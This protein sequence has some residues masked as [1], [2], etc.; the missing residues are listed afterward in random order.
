[1]GPSSQEEE[2]V[3]SLIYATFTTLSL[4][5]C[6]GS[7]APPTAAPHAA[8]SEA[9]AGDE[10]GDVPALPSA[11]PAT[12]PNEF[13]VHKSDPKTTREGPAASSK[14][15]GNA[16]HAALKFIVVDKDSG[17]IEGIIIA[18]T[19]PDG[20]KH[21]TEATNGEG[22]S[23][24]LVPVGHKYEL[25]YLS[26]G[27][28]DMGASVAVTDEPN[29]NIRLTLR[30]KRH[31]PPARATPEATSNEPAVGFIL[32]AVTFDS[33]KAVVRE[34]SYRQLDDLAEYMRQKKGARVEISGHTDNVG[35]PKVNKSL[36]HKRALAVRDYLASKGV[37]A[38]R[39]EA[40]GYGDE[41]PLAPN[42][43]EQGRARNRRIEAT[44]L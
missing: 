7:S 12:D 35:N 33:G 19:A 14:L 40:V 28:K 25:V 44:E 10:A 27:R 15:R 29:Q 13:V 18:L 41:R 11:Q 8:S 38:E 31:T 4:S 3:R 16:T 9:S 43:T 34:P 21:Y 30:Y 39:I 32:D 36:S 2:R 37:E 23:E 24:L 17:P 42:D 5:A 20:T 22:F 1:M 26:L 6:G